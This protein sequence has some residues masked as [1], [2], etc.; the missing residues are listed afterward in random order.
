LQRLKLTDVDCFGNT[1]GSIRYG[2]S[3]FGSGT[4]SYTVN[5][6]S[7]VTGQTASTFT[8]PN[9]GANTFCGVTDIPQDVA[10]ATL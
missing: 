3:G 7:P 6:G 9:L 5:G 2:V 10:T 4:Y 1:T 8:L